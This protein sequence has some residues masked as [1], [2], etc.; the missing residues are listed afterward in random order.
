MTPQSSNM[1]YVEL[2]ICFDSYCFPSDIKICYTF[3]RLFIKSQ[4]SNIITE[5]GKRNVRC[6]VVHTAECKSLLSKM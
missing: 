6:L 3:C 2:K 4:N 1:T 5:V